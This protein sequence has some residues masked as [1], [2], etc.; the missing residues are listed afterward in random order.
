MPDALD[1][2]GPPWQA[3]VAALS[4][5]AVAA[6]CSTFETEGRIELLT[7]TNSDATA[8]LRLRMPGQDTQQERTLSLVTALALAAGG[9]ALEGVWAPD[10][11]ALTWTGLARFS[12]DW[13]LPPGPAGLQPMLPEQ[14]W[15]LA[16]FDFRGL[17]GMSHSRLRTPGGSSFGQRIV[18]TAS[19]TRIDGPR[20]RVR[21]AVRALA[22]ASPESDSNLAAFVGSAAAEVFAGEAGRTGADGGVALLQWQLLTRPAPDAEWQVVAGSPAGEQPAAFTRRRGAI[23]N[24]LLATLEE[25]AFGSGIHSP[26]GM[27]DLV[28]L[29]LDADEDGDDDSGPPVQHPVD[30][31]DTELNTPVEET[32]LRR[33]AANTA[34][35]QVTALLA[36]LMP[37][38]RELLRRTAEGESD[39]EIANA[40]GISQGNVRQIRLRLRRKLTPPL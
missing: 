18:A 3:V 29:E 31:Q 28:P 32:V 20:G 27:R 34:V 19:R 4:A 33:E 12:T 7:R 23:F 37:R 14:A 15:A 35:E 16:C 40:M 24:T 30:L 25:D 8:R 9:A 10:D 21:E 13:T 26:R 22:A 11:R 2:L 6:T 36:Q 5:G 39:E 38:E 1:T 17:A